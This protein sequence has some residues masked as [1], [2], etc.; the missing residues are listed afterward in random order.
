MLA[1]WTDHGEVDLSLVISYHNDPHCNGVHVS[2][3]TFFIT[4]I[5]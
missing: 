3:S 5:N 2:E 1:K 4:L